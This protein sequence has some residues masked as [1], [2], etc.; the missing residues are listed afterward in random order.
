[1]KED[2][3]RLLNEFLAETRDDRYYEEDLQYT[4][5][6]PPKKIWKIRE[7]NLNALI[8]WLNL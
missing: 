3:K 2:L 8:E 1:M 5:S 7:P 6:M 4:S